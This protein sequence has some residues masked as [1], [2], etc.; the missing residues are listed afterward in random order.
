MFW[1]FRVVIPE[2]LQSET[3][4]FLHATHLGII[5]MKAMAR[6]CCWWPNQNKDLER[7]VRSCEPCLLTRSNPP[8]NELLPWKRSEEVWSRIHIDFFGPFMK[9][10]CLIIV[11]STS[12]WL[13][14]VDMGA[15]TTSTAV[16]SVLRDMF[17]RFGLPKVLVSDNGTQLVSSQF[18]MFLK[19][20]GIEHITSPVGYPATNGQAENSVKTV[21]QA[22]ARNLHNVPSS[23]FNNVLNRFLLDYR[24]TIHLS[25]GVSPAY[26]MF[27]RRKIRCRLDL[28]NEK[29]DVIYKSNKEIA[30]FVAKQQG[31]QQENF[32]GS[33][34]KLFKINDVVMVK[35]YS[36]PNNVV[37]TKAIISQKIGKQTYIV[38]TFKNKIWRRHANQIILRQTEEE[39]TMLSDP[40]QTVTPM[41]VNDQNTSKKENAI[42]RE[43]NQE[44]SASVIPYNLRSRRKSQ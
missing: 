29:R 44:Q 21:K 1:G 43:E 32:K 12:K 5:K 28:L 26:I 41:I 19:M 10:W 11:D 17:A 30:A 20:N 33:R 25:T 40:L 24:N 39:N 27:N 31:K 34:Q 38:K 4:K 15:N 36:R 2:K 14:C 9:R 35:D 18:E 16:I 23:E 6:E 3:L 22:L 13:E 37:W 7:V 42:V 8:T